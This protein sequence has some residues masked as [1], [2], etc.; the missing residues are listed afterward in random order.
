MKNK[1][2]FFIPFVSLTLITLIW[3]FYKDDGRRW[4]HYREEFLFLP[5]QFL[6]IIMPLFYLIAF[7]VF[8]VRQI[9]KTTRSES[10]IFYLVAS[11]FLALTSFGAL[12]A[13]FVFTSGL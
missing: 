12:C 11:P 10:N 2:L 1:I 8:L 4:Y 7:I 6:H 3:Y 9:D 5:L 13:F